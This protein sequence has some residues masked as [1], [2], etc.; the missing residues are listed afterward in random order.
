LIL[1]HVM[2]DALF[3]SKEALIRQL[4]LYSSYS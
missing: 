3:V 4:N 1:A 2:T